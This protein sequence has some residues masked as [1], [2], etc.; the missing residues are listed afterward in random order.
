MKH[1]LLLTALSMG[2]ALAADPVRVG[3]KLDTEGQLLGNMI[4]LTLNDMGIKTVNKTTL[5]DTG[6]TRRALTSGEIDIYPEYTGTALNVFFKDQ[7]FD[8]ALAKNAKKSYATVK[9]LDAKNGIVWLAPAP[10]NNTWAV[11]VPQKFAQAN[12]LV[13][14]A[15]F[16][17][18]VNSG[19]TVKVAGSPEYFNRPDSFPAFEQAYGFKLKPDQKLQL[20]GATTPQTESAAAQGTSGVNVAMAYGTDGSL[21]GLN[22][23]VLTDPKGAQPVYQPAPTIRAE[24]LKAYPGVQARLDR[25]F[26]KLDLKTLQSLNRQIALEGK[27]ARDVA[28]TYLKSNKLIK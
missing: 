14:L 6:T 28:Q 4:I 25:V 11:A 18:Y 15:D 20:A 13:S 3:S 23:V 21:A 19:G 2:T 24:V 8:K 17:R 5:G 7:K 22:L 16:A 10:A 27:N 12:K 9:A 26:T 1:L